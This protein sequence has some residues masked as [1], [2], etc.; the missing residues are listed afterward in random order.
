MKLAFSL[1]EAADATGYGLT[2]IKEAIA[3]NDLVPRYANRKPVIPADELTRWI[4]S[5][6]T[7]SPTERKRA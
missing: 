4:N 5:L 2:T 6:P 3:A 7:T 1:P